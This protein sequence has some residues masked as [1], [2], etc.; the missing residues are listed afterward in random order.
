[1]SGGF[2]CNPSIIPAIDATPEA[3]IT[4]DGWFPDVDPALLRLQ[5]RIRDSVTPERLREAIL[6]AMISIGNVLAAWRLP[7]EMSGIA[8]L[9]DVPAAQL[10]GESRLVLLYRRAIA[11]QT[12]ADLVERYRDMDLTGAG[13]R[14]V[15]DLDQSVEELRRDATHAVRDMLGR[16]RTDVELI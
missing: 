13:Q 4:N 16:T 2:N 7:L 12:K 6:G 3:V 9:A 5:V 8:S 1:M 10:G 15:G 14:Q 11:A